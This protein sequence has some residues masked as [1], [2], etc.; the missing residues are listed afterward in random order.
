MVVKLI[1]QTNTKPSISNSNTIEL[2]Y[3]YNKENLSKINDL[4][5]RFP[6]NSQN[7]SVI[8]YKKE[9]YK[10]EN[11]YI[12]PK[13]HEG[14]HCGEIVI[15]H[16]ASGKTPNKL[17]VVLF[18]ERKT[19]NP[20]FTSG[21]VLT[22]PLIQPHDLGRFVK[23]GEK[24]ASYYVSKDKYPVVI[25]NQGVTVNDTLPNIKGNAKSIYKELFEPNTFDV[26][27]SIFTLQ[28]KKTQQTVIATP[29]QLSEKW[30]ETN[31]KTKEGFDSLKGDGTYMECVA[32]DED[33]NDEIADYAVVPLNQSG[34][35]K[36][37]STVVYGLGSVIILIVFIAVHY[38]LR[39]L[40]KTSFY[41]LKYE[42]VITFALLIIGI[43]L[44]LVGALI[45]KSN[46]ASTR[47]VIS[48][49]VFSLFGLAD[50]VLAFLQIPEKR[51][52]EIY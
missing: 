7:D 27:S 24:S 39:T 44:C 28:D 30:F 20:F 40:E 5:Y 42:M 21:D 51:E 11:I 13:M 34:T 52:V 26:L 41:F 46:P 15:E 36:A 19:S 38:F 35:A 22:F 3:S 29:I 9:I 49:V 10:G 43:V 12:T 45:D 31:D 25:F 37:Y 48:G 4:L 16:V 14:S 50:G 8:E 18:L 17:Y 2:L 47:L 32:L 1:T 6:E 23:T 33:T